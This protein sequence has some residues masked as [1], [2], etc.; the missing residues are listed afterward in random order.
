MFYGMIVWGE[1][2]MVKYVYMYYFYRL[3]IKEYNFINRCKNVYG[4]KY[5]FKFN[6]FFLLFIFFM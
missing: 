2:F 1:Y 4:F 6:I 3:N 5:K